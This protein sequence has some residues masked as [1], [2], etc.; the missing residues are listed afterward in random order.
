MAVSAVATTSMSS[1]TMN[2]ARGLKASTHPW[3]DVDWWSLS[4][5]AVLSM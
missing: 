2:D 1:T 5:L 3:A 4:V